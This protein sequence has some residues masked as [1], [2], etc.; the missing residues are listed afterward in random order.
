MEEKLSFEEALARL[1]KAVD[2][3]RS[4]KCSLEESVK[5]YEESVKYYELCSAFLKDARQKIE[6]Y[7]PGTG[8]TE[9]F[10]EH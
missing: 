6:V 3:L 5:I 2:Q 4:G 9:A 7:R 1:E 8:Q 10:D